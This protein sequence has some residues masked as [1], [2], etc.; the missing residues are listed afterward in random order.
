MGGHLI[1][2]SGDIKLLGLR[3]QTNNRFNK[4]INIRLNL[5]KKFKFHLSKNF[6]SAKIDTKIKTNMYKLYVRSILMYALP[7]WCRKPQV[8]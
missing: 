2:P 3:L 4:H 1:P 6:G 8:T 5:A 7:V